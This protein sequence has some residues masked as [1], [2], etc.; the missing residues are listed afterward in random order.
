MNTIYIIGRWKY[1]T[2]NKFRCLVYPTEASFNHTISTKSFLSNEIEQER[3]NISCV[4]HEYY[5]NKK[6]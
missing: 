2:C 3:E 5:G 6:L 1:A 4:L